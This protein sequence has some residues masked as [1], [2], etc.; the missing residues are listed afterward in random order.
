MPHALF[1]SALHISPG[2]LPFG[3][4]PFLV[5]REYPPKGCCF[6]WPPFHILPSS[7][8]HPLLVWGQGVPWTSSVLSHL[9]GPWGFAWLI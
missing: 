3:W 8:Q 9:V 4:P 7:H 6:L 2:P 1:G 5:W